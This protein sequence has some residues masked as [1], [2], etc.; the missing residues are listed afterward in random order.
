MGD[1]AEA[2]LGYQWV[3]RSKKKAIDPLIGM[4]ITQFERLCFVTYVR[5]HHT[6]QLGGMYIMS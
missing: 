2:F 6:K 3:M 1:H 5:D 4:F